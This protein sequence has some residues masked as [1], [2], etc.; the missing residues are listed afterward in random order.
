MRNEK[1]VQSR[2]ETLRRGRGSCREFALLMMGPFEVRA[3][4]HQLLAVSHFVSLGALC[5]TLALT[6]WGT[7][8]LEIARN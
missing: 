7:L 1:G 6:S 4:P 5:S 2:S 3:H 8:A